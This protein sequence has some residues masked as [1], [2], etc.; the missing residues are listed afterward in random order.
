M[1]MIDMMKSGAKT[2]CILFFIFL[3]AGRAGAEPGAFAPMSQGDLMRYTRTDGDDNSWTVS[4][5]IVE[6]TTFGSNTY[7]HYWAT[8]YSPGSLDDM[9]VRSTADTV[10][11]WD[12]DEEKEEILFQTGPV[13]LNW[14]RG[15]DEIT[16]TTIIDDD[17]E[18][19][20]PYGGPYTTWCYRMK[21]DDN[22][23]TYV[24]VAE[25]L[26]IV[27]VEDYWVANPPKISVLLEVDVMGSPA[28]FGPD[29]AS[30]TNRYTPFS[31]GDKIT[32]AGYGRHANKSYVME[33]HGEETKAGVNCLKVRQKHIVDGVVESDDHGLLAQDVN[34]D[35][36]IMMHEDLLSGEIDEFGENFFQPVLWMPANPEVGQ[37]FFDVG[38][39]YHQV[40][41]ADVVSPRLPSGAGPYEDCL[42]FVSHHSPTDIDTHWLAPNIG[43]V[44]EEH[45][46]NEQQTP[47]GYELT[48]HL[49]GSPEGSTRL[50]GKVSSD[51]DGEGVSGAVISLTPG[52]YEFVTG[53][54]GTYFSTHLPP[55]SYTATI[56]A[57]H[58]DDRTVSNASVTPGVTSV[59]NA[60]LT[61]RAPLVADVALGPDNLYNN[62]SD[63]ALLT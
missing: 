25:G 2:V 33:A 55:G 1:K 30:I 5:K 26:G 44:L 61:P 37:I 28:E 53:S 13:G 6:T 54:D 60:T 7:F 22:P 51:G 52:G 15:T 59:L 58:H 48:E 27:K 38:D 8:N 40:V 20:T 32:L 39:S 45:R 23:Y 34:G 19:T 14:S 42:K 4:V 31:P 56:S 29:S 36:W 16:V 24:W 12:E 21:T 18:I 17:D 57:S 11:K 9:Y 63:F 3:I 62:W 10:Y 47:R 35:V 41:A 49:W 43:P 46:D 50:E